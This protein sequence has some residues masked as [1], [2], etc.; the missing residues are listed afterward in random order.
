MWRYM[1]RYLLGIGLCLG[2]QVT[3]PPIAVSAEL[4]E[5]EGRGRLIVAVKDNRYP[6]AYRDAVGELH[7]F[8]IE[9]ARRL[10]LALLGDE[11]AV[12]LRPVNNI[13]R[14]NAVIEGDVDIA[15]AAITVTSQRQRITSFSEPYYLDGV[16]FITTSPQVTSLA[17]LTL[18]RI[19][20]L[21][22]SSTLA[23]VRYQL[24][25]AVV[26]P[27]SSYQQAVAA[28]GDGQVDAFAGDIS[29]LTGWQQQDSHY[30]LLDEVISVEPIAIAIPKGTQYS[31]L[32]RA[33][34]DALR[35][36]DDEGWLQDRAAHWGLR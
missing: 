24:P 27:V 23:Q 30:R 20:V 4:T 25:A 22:D 35:Q 2:V 29:L 16:G 21:S 12:E 33:I 6:L 18:G 28:L 9:I 13:D 36:W 15:I 11:T 7:G 31:D 17:D 1:W 34:N 3:A 26:I 19:A 8:E 14:V 32:R 5:I 10:A